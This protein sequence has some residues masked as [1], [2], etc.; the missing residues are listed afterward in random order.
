MLVDAAVELCVKNGYENTT[1]EQVAAAADISTRTFSRYFPTKEA[2]FIAVLDDLAAEIATE[3]TTQP[4]DLGPMEALRAAHMAVLGRVSRHPLVGLTKE[5]VALIIRIIN[6][7]DALRQAAIDY[8][9]PAAMDILARHMGV[10][11]DDKRLDLAVKLFSTTIVSACGNLVN[12]AGEAALG[13]EIIMERLEQS[14][15][16]VTQFAADI[17]INTAH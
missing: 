14:L 12:E 2:V 15:G 13:P 8:R 6:S 17:N 1:V 4:T 16:H 3:L 10:P 7:S 11:A 9:Y 5:R